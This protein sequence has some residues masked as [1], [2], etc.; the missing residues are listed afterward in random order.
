MRIK[1]CVRFFRRA[2]ASGVSGVGDRRCHRGHFSGLELRDWRCQLGARPHDRLQRVDRVRGLRRTAEAAAVAATVT[3]VYTAVAAAVATDAPT[4]AAAA[5][6][7]ATLAATSPAPSAAAIP[8][9]RPALFLRR[10]VRPLRVHLQRDVR[11]GRLGGVPGEMSR[12]SFQERQR[13]ITTV[14]CAESACRS[15]PPSVRPSLHPSFRACTSRAS[16]ALAWSWDLT[17]HTTR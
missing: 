14:I 15:G 17:S 9:C 3:A 2:S 10:A 13:P 1:R 12:D 8:P 11:R 7:A 6:A 5:T 4:V 16:A